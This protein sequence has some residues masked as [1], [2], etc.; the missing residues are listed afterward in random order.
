MTAQQ[1]N[2]KY[3]GRYVEISR[4]YNYSTRQNEYEVLR[5]YKYIHE[6]TT[7]GEDVGTDMEYCR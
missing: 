5:S 3:R 7:L 2:K 4:V 1:I 6:N